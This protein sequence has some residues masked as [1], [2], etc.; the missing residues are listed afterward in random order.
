MS[1]NRHSDHHRNKPYHK[2]PTVPP[3]SPRENPE[4]NRNYS[5]CKFEVPPLGKKIWG[6]SISERIM[7]G[8]TTAAVLIAAATG[9]VVYFQWKGMKT[10]Q[11]AWVGFGEIKRFDFEVDKPVSVTIPVEN[12]GKTPAKSIA[13]GFQLVTVEKTADLP[14]FDKVVEPVMGPPAALLL[15]NQVHDMTAHIRTTTTTQSDPL[16]QVYY[17]QIN[18]G[19]VVVYAIGK[20]TYTDIFNIDHWTK[21]C[22]CTAKM[23][24]SEKLQFRLCR[25]PYSGIDSEEQ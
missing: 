11:R 1:K 13:S 20:A 18:S 21:V 22:Y 15:P 5:K 24:P 19:D 14:D 23:S 8:L 17:D 2:P 12:V 4:E 16:P 7:A 10:D 3:T 6:M 25:A 9:L